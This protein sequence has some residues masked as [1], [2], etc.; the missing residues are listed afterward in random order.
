MVEKLKL[1]TIVLLLLVAVFLAVIPVQEAIANEFEVSQYHAVYDVQPNG[2]V[3]VT[4]DITYYFSFDANGIYRDIDTNLGEDIPNT[5]EN[6][7]GLDYVSVAV[8]EDGVER[9]LYM[10]DEGGGEDGLFEFFETQ[11]R[12][13][14]RL[15]VFEET[16]YESKTFRFSYTLTNAVTKF[17][18]IATLNW[19]MIDKNWEVYLSDVKITIRIPEGAEKSEL[20]IY[21]HGDLTGYNEIVDARTFNVQVAVVEPGTMVENLVIFPLELV[22]DSQKIIQRTELPTIL[23][24]EAEL[25]EQANRERDE[26]K[27]RVEEYRKQQ[28]AERQ[29]E[30]ARQARNKKMNPIL[31]ILG[32][33]GLGGSAFVTRKYGRERKPEFQGD[34]YRELPG[35]YTPA[36]MSYLL[37]NGTIESK[38]IMA[39]LMDLARK[40]IIAIEPYEKEKRSLFGNKTE[41]DYRLISRRP[42]A[43]EL[44]NLTNHERF[45]FD[46][47][48][49]DLGD[50][51]SLAMD[52]LEATLKTESNAR[53]FNRDY[54]QFKSYIAGMGESFNFREA[55]K[56]TGSGKFYLL[57]FGLIGIA[58]LVVFFIDNMMGLVPGIAGV[59]MLST[60]GAMAAK[61]KLTQYGSDQVAMWKAFK[62]F[63]ETFSNM[64]KAEIPA[65]TIWNH[66]LVYATSLGIAKEVIEQ[67]P[68][69]Y[70]TQE[71]SDPTFTSTFY[72]GF[73]FG[74]GF[75][76]MDRSLNKAIS[77][78]TQTIEKAEAV[79]S[80]RRSSSM[81]GGGG[82]SG[83][84]SGGGG[85]GGGGGAF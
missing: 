10:T 23:E 48:I 64:D 76:Q 28:E 30:L 44:D 35:D 65:L 4:E 15:K 25:A 47:F 6:Q 73:Y 45:L 1:K 31:W 81:G 37:E 54:D 53:Q 43:E 70:S 12:K 38:D 5:P 61:R 82:F 78:A 29:A 40:K 9:P 20:K 13:V 34:Y 39:T 52:D 79:A 56:T 11:Q 62:R 71:L 7:V 14:Y 19:K 60:M 22:P 63:L 46:W 41:T 85:G 66:Y 33:L 42:H 50:G 72:P 58:V 24:R 77:T 32:A 27:K 26:A 55:N 75:T 84:S 51:S 16:S 2:D 17:N 18:D 74:R 59:I 57:G 36:V 69:A 67:L 8:L 49:N 80:S 68:K 83:G 21:S 3:K